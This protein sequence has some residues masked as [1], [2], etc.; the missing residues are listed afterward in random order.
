MVCGAFLEGWTHNNVTGE[1]G[2]RGAD[3]I[4]YR[5]EEHYRANSSAGLSSEAREWAEFEQECIEKAI[6]GDL[7]VY[8]GFFPLIKNEE[9]KTEE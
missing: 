7:S 2:Y 6:N 3:G 1:Y 5:S 8:D 4:M 9:E